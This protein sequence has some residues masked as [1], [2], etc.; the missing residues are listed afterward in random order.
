MKDTGK[1][2]AD[3]V[4]NT[5]PYIICVQSSKPEKSN[6]SLAD[7]AY[8]PDEFVTAKGKLELDI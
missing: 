7:K 4:G 3:L 5:I 1:S 6:P 8:H 2:D